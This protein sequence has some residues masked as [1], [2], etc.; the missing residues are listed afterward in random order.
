[1]T[2]RI[3]KLQNHIKVL[4]EKLVKE[5]GLSIMDIPEEY[6]TNEL[7][8]LAIRN[9]SRI[10]TYISQNDQTS[11]LCLEAV[12]HDGLQYLNCMSNCRTDEIKMEAVKQNGLILRWMENPT[13]EMQKEAVKS[14]PNAIQYIK[15][16]SIELQKIAVKNDITILY[17][18]KYDIDLLELFD[19]KIL[20]EWRTEECMKCNIKKPYYVDLSIDDKKIFIKD[21]LSNY[22]YLCLDCLMDI[23]KTGYDDEENSFYIKI[24]ELY[25]KDI[26]KSVYSN[27]KNEIN[28]T[29]DECPVCKEVKKYYTNYSCDENHIICLECFEKNK[30]CYYKC[31][32]SY[33]SRNLLINDAIKNIN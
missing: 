22:I 3:K 23:V 14:Y 2:T 9:N 12:K 10:L 11:E 21:H 8:K 28:K 25:V 7:W 4:H 26:F 1:M 32:Y 20:S 24:I 18:E 13:Y 33:K 17:Y 16:P 5:N 27:F 31:H 19:K 15:N 6:R 30:S 29:I